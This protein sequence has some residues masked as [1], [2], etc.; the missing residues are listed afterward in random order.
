MAK[1]KEKK[2]EIHWVLTRNG[3]VRNVFDSR[4]KAVK[5]LKEMLQQTLT[6]FRIQDKSDEY[7]YEINIPETKIYPVEERPSYLSIT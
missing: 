1:K 7:D 4:K 3:E 5:H 2:E 6:D